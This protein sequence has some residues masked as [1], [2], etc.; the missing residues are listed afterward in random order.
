M[1]IVVQAIP[2]FPENF[3]AILVDVFE[4][5]SSPYQCVDRQ[6]GHLEYIH[7]SRTSGDLSPL[8]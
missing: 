7:T 1:I 6:Y 8:L 4:P 2:M 5:D 3:Q